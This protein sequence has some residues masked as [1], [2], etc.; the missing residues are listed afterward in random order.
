MAKK[1]IIICRTREEGKLKTFSIYAI[2][3]EAFYETWQKRAKEGA[4]SFCTLLINEELCGKKS[5]KVL[6][7]L[8]DY[9][10]IHR[11]LWKHLII[12]FCISDAF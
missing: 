12:A 9:D 4:A 3:S 11:R 10:N 1:Y 5:K 7:M 6:Q 2:I 8:K